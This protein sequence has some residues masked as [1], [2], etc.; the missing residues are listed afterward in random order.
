V[1]TLTMGAGPDV[2]CLHG[3]GATKASFLDT[4]AA[5]RRAGYR[6]HALDPPGFGG[7]SKPIA[8]P[9][10]A[11]W[12]AETVVDVMDELA[13]RHARLVGNSMSASARRSD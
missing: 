1:S 4:A 5:V 7:A 10:S 2:V 6:V 8:A 13:I 3:L 11:R 12:F 9:Y